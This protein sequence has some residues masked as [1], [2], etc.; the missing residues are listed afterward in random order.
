MSVRESCSAIRSRR[1]VVIEGIVQGVG[2]R[3][4]VAGLA[5]QF[6]VD[7]FVG[8]DTNGVFLE[9][10]GTVDALDAFVA[11]VAAG[12]PPLAR[13][14]RV[15]SADMAPA[16]ARGFAIVTST[17]GSGRDALVTADAGSCED[18]RREI[19]DP[20]DRRFGYAFTN[21]TNCGPRFTIVRGVP[22]DRSTT[23]MAEFPMCER[24]R[25]EYD[26]PA[27]RR[28]HAQPVCCPDCGPR[29]V[30]FDRD[31]VTVAG[32][33]IETTAARL[34]AGQIVAV[35]GLGGY[36]LA[37][38]AMNE[39]AVARLRGRKHREDR[40]FAV[41]VASL[42]QARELCEVDDDE[43]LL[44][45]GPQR[46]IVL[47]RRRDPAPSPVGATV[48]ATG[49]VVAPSLAPRCR[50]LGVMLPYTPLHD[51]LMDAT[52]GPLVMTSGNVSDEPIA[53]DDA[54]ARVRLAPIAEAFL[55]HDRQIVTRVDDSVMRVVRRRPLALRRSR[56]FA[57]VPVSVPW[58]FPRPV[59]GCG[60][61]LKSTFCLGRGRHAFL[62][63]HI[64]DLE[65]FE[66]FNAFTR[67]I[68]HLETLLG[69]VP[70]VV[71]HDLHPDYL[72]TAYATDLDGV[73]LVGVQHH[74]AHIASCLADNAVAGPVIGVAFDGTGY[75]TDAT[76]WGGEFLVADLVDAERVARLEPVPLPGGAAAIREPW[77]MLASYLDRLASRDPAVDVSV[78]AT[79]RHRERWDSVRA[80]AA[81]GVNS[82]LTS[83]AGRLFDAVACLLDLRDDVTYEGQA[84]IE[85]E[86]LAW[87]ARET[88]APYAVS[89]LV[90][91]SGLITLRG[92]DLVRA[93]LSDLRAGVAPV[94]IAARFH[95]AVARMIV[96]TCVELRS[97]HDLATVALSGGVFQ[98]TLLLDLAVTGLDAAGFTTLTHRQVPPNDGGISLGQVVVAAAR[99]RGR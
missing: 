84:A 49:S 33:P 71:A 87:L 35:K 76:V 70:E 75:G 86:Q 85:L 55:A 74:H 99:D 91:D 40:P 28:Y 10:E 96:A 31:G 42:D 80:A 24:C 43:A 56:G 48:E 38:D 46:P 69:I 82:P 29:L 22:Y 9:A 66:T 14:D 78:A 81:A 41:M 19:R 44:L 62:S 79:E 17:S 1:R 97:R 83:S 13:V 59:L 15:A 21:C 57:P 68:A 53:F 11:A 60:A 52:G 2:F 54:D 72:S 39:T 67:G 18:C 12:G 89:S 27:D 7:G 16:G 95:Q 26:D 6:G 58:E 94:E 93:V 50:E 63:H 51:L 45:A 25:R 8:N 47:L 30:A 88:P 32:D 65:N 5:A 90:D 77:R 36:H 37:V 73:A 34:R 98:N 3:P 4:F 23:S 92:T 20:A 61:E 64:G